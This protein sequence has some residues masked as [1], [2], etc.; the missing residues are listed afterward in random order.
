[1][2]T[3]RVSIG[4]LLLLGS[5]ESEVKGPARLPVADAG[6]DQ[7]VLTLSTEVVLDGSASL[8]PEGEALTFAWSAQALP[9]SSAAAL[10]DATLAAPRFTADVPGVYTFGL[11]VAAGERTSAMDTVN[12]VVLDPAFDHDYDGTLT[13][14]EYANGTDAFDADSDD[15]GLLDG[16]EDL[17]DDGTL[18]AGETDPLVVDTDADGIQD[19]TERGIA[20][21]SPDTV[22]TVFVPDGDAGASTTDPRL[23]DTDGGGVPDGTEDADHDGRQDPAE[24]DPYYEGDDDPDLDGLDNDAERLHGTRLYD[25]DSDDDGLYDG[26][27]SGVLEGRCEDKDNDG[28]FLPTAGETDPTSFD[29]DRD[30]IPDSVETRLSWALVTAD[31]RATT[32]REDADTANAPTTPLSGWESLES[33]CTPEHEEDLNKNGALEPGETNPSFTADDRCSDTDND[34]LSHDKEFW[35]MTDQNDRD[36]DDDG[37][38]DGCSTVPCEDKNSDGVFDKDG[39]DDAFLTPDDETDPT[40][41]DSDND[42]IQDG[43]ELGVTTAG[44]GTAS[45]PFI[46][47]LD[48]VTSPPPSKNTGVWVIDNDGGCDADGIEDGN[49]NGRLDLNESFNSSASDD[50]CADID[51]DGLNRSLELRGGA[52]SF[53]YDANASSRDMDG[54]GSNDGKIFPASGARL[55]PF[56]EDQDLDGLVGPGERSSLD[57]D[58]D[59]DGLADAV[60]TGT[61]T[62]V[63]LTNTGTDPADP[64]TDGDGILDGVELGRQSGVLAPVSPKC[65]FGTAAGFVGDADNAAP[66]TSPLDPDSDDDCLADGAE[67][68]DRNGRVDGGETDPNAANAGNC[69]L[70]ADGDSDGDTLL[71]AAETTTDP[72]AADTD[73]DGVRDDQDAAPLVRDGDGG[74][75]IDGIEVANGTDPTDPSDDSCQDPDDDELTNGIERL[76]GTDPLLA[77]TD[78]D[79]LWDG[80]DPDGS[81]PMQGEDVNRNSVL[82]FGETDPLL[83][84]TDGDGIQDGT[85][86][87]LTVAAPGTTADATCQNPALFCP[88]ADPTS[89]TLATSFGVSAAFADPV[90]TDGGGLADGL[91]DANHNGR[92]DPLETDPTRRFDEARLADDDGDGLDR[93]EEYLLGTNYLDGDTDDDGVSDGDEALV[94]GTDP[95]SWDSDRDG[96]QDGTELG[97]TAADVDASTLLTTYTRLF[98]SG[99]RAGFMADTDSTVATATDVLDFDS[100]GP[101]GCGVPD[102]WEDLDR[103]GALDVGE[104]DPTVGSD[105]TASAFLGTDPSG[106]EDGDGLCNGLELALGSSRTDADSDDDGLSDYVEVMTTHT[107]PLQRDSDHDRIQDGTELGLVLAD[108]VAG[109]AAVGTSTTIFVPDADPASTTDPRLADS[110]TGGRL[111]GFEDSNRN[112]AIDGVETDPTSP[113][114]G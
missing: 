31:T 98:V 6:D 60:E 14:A 48:P 15:D 77:D 23:Q 67:D 46:A 74:C 82:D 13:S 56:G 64:D 52:G 75:D 54:D 37:L 47:D 79:G 97:V 96:L 108:I 50:S 85:E 21:P 114:D 28:V 90:D 8:D 106:D 42:G 112:G 49:Q 55:P 111:D 87:G 100:D 104:T 11:R 84:D 30:G 9:S 113:S 32:F 12:V 27:P 24:T 36:S 63:D 93:N 10:D 4:L 89:T 83:M 65:C 88:D 38:A 72:Y 105:D 71:D 39:L 1:M 7:H 51:Q 94:H 69:D 35:L 68:A 102:G 76:L 101:L 91:E 43:T 66:N 107:D 110:D 45:P 80:P 58:T 95:L 62:F 3:T 86:R 17:D 40:D 19:G 20:T 78:G 81:G 70:D 41:I 57:L 26:C 44:S 33:G 29:T 99:T 25:A 53:T 34:G 61:G 2:R 22:T 16:A 103:D 109:G 5:C 73:D 92:V 59:D 18:G